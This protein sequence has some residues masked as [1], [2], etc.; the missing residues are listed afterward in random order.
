MADEIDDV[1][2]A[3]DEATR[4][5]KRLRKRPHH[6]IDFLVEAADG[7]LL[8]AEVAGTLDD[9]AAVETELRALFAALGS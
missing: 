7:D 2:I 9:P 5:S 1:A 6:E 3:G 4:G 8:K